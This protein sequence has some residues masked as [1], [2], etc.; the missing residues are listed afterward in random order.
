MRWT[1]PVNHQRDSQNARIALTCLLFIFL[2]SVFR[3]HDNNS[4]PL[5]RLSTAGP[6]VPPAPQSMSSGM[7]STS[8]TDLHSLLW[9]LREGISCFFTVSIPGF[10]ESGNAIGVFLKNAFSFPIQIRMQKEDSSSFHSLYPKIKEWLL[11]NLAVS[12]PACQK[13]RNGF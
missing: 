7:H 4:I 1:C 2:W 13:L 8:F 11:Q 9:D 5:P 6:A 12:I 10:H 3:L